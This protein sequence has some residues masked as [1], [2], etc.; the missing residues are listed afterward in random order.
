MLISEVMKICNLT[1]KA[2]SYYE[3]QGLIEISYNHNGYREFSAQ[4]ITTLKEISALRKLGMSVADIKSFL[5]S[6][7]RHA[8]LQ[9]H[10]SKIEAEIQQMRAQYHCVNYLLE[11]NCTLAE[12]YNEIDDRLDGTMIIKDKIIQA[13]P[14]PYGEYLYIHFGK[15]LDGK[16]D[17]R[18]KVEAYNRIVEFLDNGVHMEMPEDL[19]QYMADSF[20]SLSKINLQQLDENLNSMVNNYE[21]YMDDNKDSIDAYIAYR[22]SEEFKASPAYRMQQILLEFNK[23][24]GYDEIFIPN[25]KILSSSYQQYHDKLQ[26][27]NE[28]LLAEYP[29]LKSL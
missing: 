21:Q 8:A 9:D 22:N 15:Y 28:M 16:L 5:A 10:K 3:Q 2:I 25:M 23:S 6:D 4:D 27:A 17:S 26:V 11:G 29:Q 24:S 13:F 19:Q 12:A 1:K 7:D 20:A 18:E 14:G